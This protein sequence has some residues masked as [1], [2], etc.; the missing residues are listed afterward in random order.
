[1][2]TSE[3]DSRPSNERFV[4]FLA[5]YGFDYRDTNGYSLAN[6]FRIRREDAIRLFEAMEASRRELETVAKAGGHAYR[7]LAAAHGNETPVR[8]PHW[9]CRTHSDFDAMR[10]VGCPECMR[11]ARGALEKIIHMW[12]GNECATVAREALGIWPTGPAV[13]APL[14]ANASAFQ[15]C[16]K[17]APKQCIRPA[18]HDG[19]CD[20]VAP[21]ADEPP[22]TPW[23]GASPNKGNPP[24][25]RGRQ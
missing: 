25:S 11:L 8:P 16:L 23:P 5:R 20:V 22:A 15:V 12:P 24:D 18:G 10:A 17:A 7:E 13:G 1:M 14:K 6:C 9:T 21:K 2:T 4:G 19:E 3:Q